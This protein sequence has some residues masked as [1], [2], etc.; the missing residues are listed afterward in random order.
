MPFPAV[1]PLHSKMQSLQ[2]A[3]RCQEHI[4]VWR[5]RRKGEEE[6]KREPCRLA[7]NGTAEEKE[8]ERREAAQTEGLWGPRG[9]GLPM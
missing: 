1:L 4:L 3:V 9:A 7:W 8:R 6:G 2:L 5:K